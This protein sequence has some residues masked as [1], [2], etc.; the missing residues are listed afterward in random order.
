MES[1]RYKILF[2][3]FIAAEAAGSQIIIWDGLPI[4]RRLLSDGVEGGATKDFVLALSAVVLMQIGHWLAFRLMPHLHFRRN[5]VLGH[6]LVCIG[7]LSL[8][9]ASALAVVI[10]FDRFSE[11]DVAPWKLLILAAILFAVCCYKHQL[12]TLAE[13]MINAPAGAAESDHR[14]PN[15]TLR[16]A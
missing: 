8:F 3:C 16:Q 11:L 1:S 10:V 15:E 14:P 6:V 5:V 9:F 4:Y 7:E 2:W 12:E 13:A